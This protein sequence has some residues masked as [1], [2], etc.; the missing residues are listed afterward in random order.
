MFLTVVVSVFIAAATG[1][2]VKFICG[3]KSREFKITWPE[4]W[5]VMAIIAVIAAPGSVYVGWQVAKHSKTTFHEY[6]NGW[7]LAAQ[8]EDVACYRDG[9]CRWEYD[10]DPYLVSYSC[11]CDNKGNCSTCYRTEYHD[12]PYVTTETHYHVETT[13]GTYTIDKYRFPDNPQN[14]R[15]RK[16]VSIPNSVIEKAGTGE[17]LFWTEAKKR[18]QSGYPGPVTQRHDYKNYIY[19]SDKSILT[20][21]S[22]AVVR[23]EK[24]GLL[25]IFQKDIHNFYYADK[26]YFVGF[27]PRN[28]MEWYSAASYLNAATGSSLRGD[29]H[30]VIVNSSKIVNLDEYALSLRAFWQDKN[31][32]GK[33]S[34]SKNAIVIVCA[35]DGQK[36]TWARS[37]T[38][39]P[40]GNEQMLAALDSQLRG[41]AFD[42]AAVIGQTRGILKGGNVKNELG[43]GIIENIIFGI[44]EPSTKF[45]R[46]SMEAKDADDFGSGFLYLASEIQPTPSQR[47]WIYIATFLFCG[48]GWI[49]AVIRK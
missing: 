9:P 27:A 28:F 13:L 19:A 2:V 21:Y 35:T 20:Q 46:V 41:A 34:L 31:H 40:L 45:R 18:I 30:L 4:Y 36:I 8:K 42:P 44:S 10:C 6:W 37:F 12:C 3:R 15:W 29:I 32:H 33:D 24:S 43:G 47:M 22:D 26:V 16:R 39:M 11:N 14:Y 38:G 49:V 25:P 5:M 7:E 1:L 17:P 23:Y 48:I